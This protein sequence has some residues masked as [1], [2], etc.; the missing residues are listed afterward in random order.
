LK[1]NLV[2]ILCLVATVAQA[3]DYSEL[4]A[5]L[6]PSVVQI[7]DTA[8]KNIFGSGVIVS[9]D[10][11]ILT[12]LHVVS[13]S[14]KAVVILPDGRRLQA[15][16]KGIDRDHDLAL[17]KIDAHDLPAVQLSTVSPKVGQEV[18]M[19]GHP[20]GLALS[21][22]TGHVNAVN[23][24]FA[25]KEGLILTDAVV[26]HGN[27]GGPLFTLDGRVIGILSQSVDKGKG[28]GFVVPV[29]PWVHLPLKEAK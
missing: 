18:M 8:R 9:S 19:I 23:F 29:L 21:V 10:G 3:T 24:K 25:S 2:I 4:A 5:R 16:G 1:Y 26:N 13:D 17:I 22:T 12:A 6:A 11:L 15:A 7:Q 14:T 20:L 28:L 27:S